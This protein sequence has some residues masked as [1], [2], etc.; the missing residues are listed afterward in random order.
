M[1]RILK[2]F[3]VY[4]KQYKGYKAYRSILE[5]SL[6]VQHK[7]YNNRFKY[8]FIKTKQ[9]Y[10]CSKRHKKKCYKYKGQCDWCEFNLEE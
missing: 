3:F 7:T 8:A 2:H 4:L 10:L 9:W 6:S 1:I 5:E